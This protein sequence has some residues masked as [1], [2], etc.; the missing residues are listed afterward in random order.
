MTNTALERIVKM[1]NQLAEAKQSVT[2]LS[3]ALKDEK[4]RVR[5]LSTEDLP[6]LM[7]EAGLGAIELENGDKVSLRENVSV[8]ITEA[9][10]EAAMKWLTDNNFGGIIKTHVGIDFSADEFESAEETTNRLQGEGLPATKQQTVHPATLKAFVK[11]QL[12][13][14][15]EIPFD[16]FGVY[17]YAEATIKKGK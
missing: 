10:R 11:E 6:T 17:P 1:A 15:A 5:R 2:D 9:R 7:Q 12:Q 8:N 4:E 14:G 13:K 16:L 3:A